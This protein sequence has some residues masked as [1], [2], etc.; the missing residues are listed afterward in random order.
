MSSIRGTFFKCMMRMQNINPII[1]P[2]M[3]KKMKQMTVK[4]SHTKTKKV[5][6]YI[7]GGCYISGLTYNYRNFCAPFC[8][9]SE[10]TEIVLLDY[11]LSPDYIYPVQLNEALDLW[12]EL[13]EHRH[14]NPGNIILGG[15]SSGG[16]LVLALMLH[17]RD[18][19][20]EMP[21]SAFLL[22]PWTD[23]TASG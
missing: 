7:H 6:Y 5:I 20:R 4:Y 12:N 18:R 9:L 2:E 17:L 1:H 3:Q 11:K 16:N 15:D 8:D 14:I 19:K 23:M 10:G 21:N 13:T 22:S